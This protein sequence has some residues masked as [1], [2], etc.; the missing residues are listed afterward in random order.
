MSYPMTPVKRP[1]ISHGIQASDGI[2]KRPIEG[3]KKR[4]SAPI[5]DKPEH[6]IAPE[7]ITNAPTTSRLRRAPEFDVVVIMKTTKKDRKKIIQTPRRRSIKLANVPMTPKTAPIR[8]HS[9]G[10]NAA[11]STPKRRKSFGSLAPVR[12]HRVETRKVV[13]NLMAVRPPLCF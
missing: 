12:Q 9:T 1:T 7:E 2:I 10:G 6:R 4:L 3:N 8:R 13:R 11:M 5:K